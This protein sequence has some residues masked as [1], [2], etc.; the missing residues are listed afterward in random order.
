VSLPGAGGQGS[1]E[2][3]GG[4]KPEKGSPISGLL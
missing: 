1:K 3:T 2:R 4:E